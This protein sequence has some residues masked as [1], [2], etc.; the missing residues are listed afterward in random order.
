MNKPLSMFR[1]SYIDANHFSCLSNFKL[2]DETELFKIT[3]GHF[4]TSFK[5]HRLENHYTQEQLAE[6][7]DVDTHTIRNWESNKTIPKGTDL[8][9]SSQ[10]FGISIDTL[11]DA[12][13]KYKNH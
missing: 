7:L 4:S 9:N 10:L 3:G 13:N 1:H 6:L 12:E 2:L 5:Y 11:W 8:F